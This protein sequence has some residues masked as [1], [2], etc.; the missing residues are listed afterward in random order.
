[1]TSQTTSASQTPDEL[2]ALAAR[3]AI[4]GECFLKPFCDAS[5]RFLHRRRDI[6]LHGTPHWTC[7]PL[8]PLPATGR[9]RVSGN[10]SE[11]SMCEPSRVFGRITLVVLLAALSTRTTES[12]PQLSPGRA[13][14]FPS[15]EECASDRTPSPRSGQAAGGSVFIRCGATARR[16]GRARGGA[17]RRATTGRSTV[18]SRLRGRRRGRSRA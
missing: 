13:L 4:N 14:G 1:M 6:L 11:A 8:Q 12:P 18:A 2:R 10:P 5:P 17:R 9:P 15:E 16:P 3:D 7:G